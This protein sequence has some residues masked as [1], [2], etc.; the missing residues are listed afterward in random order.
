MHSI[1]NTV[2]LLK[3]CDFD[4]PECLII[5]AEQGIVPVEFEYMWQIP[6]QFY[7]LVKE[8]PDN[9]PFE[10]DLVPLWE[11]NGDY[12]VAI[13]N[14]GSKRII[15]YY[16]EDKEDQ[17]EVLGTSLKEVLK[18]SIEWLYFEGEAEDTEIISVATKLDFENPNDL[19]NEYRQ[20]ET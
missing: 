4:V 16:Y 5:L 19:L 7:Y 11:V 12:V 14:D 10:N 1:E 13:V 17:Y 6:K 2:R 3:D 20:K 9:M 15:K 8:Y 18:D